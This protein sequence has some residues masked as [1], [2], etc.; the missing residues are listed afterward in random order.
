MAPAPHEKSCPNAF[1]CHGVDVHCFSHLARCIVS[2]H[3]PVHKNLGPRPFGE[4]PARLLRDAEKA[5]FWKWGQPGPQSRHTL[6]TCSALG[7]GAFELALTLLISSDP[8]QC[9][10]AAI[11]RRACLALLWP[12]S[13][14]RAE[15]ASSAKTRPAACCIKPDKHADMAHLPFASS[16]LGEQPC[17]VSTTGQMQLDGCRLARW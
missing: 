11:P 1:F 15:N 12:C 17:G 9:A 4:V 16:P 8:W 14:S 3:H 10:A 2:L 5:G 13:T 7:D 6:K